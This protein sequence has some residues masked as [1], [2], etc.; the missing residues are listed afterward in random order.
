MIVI[1]DNTKNL[2]NASM[3]PKLIKCLK[4]KNVRYNIIS[5]RKQLYILL[6]KQP[7][8]IKGIILSGGPLCLSEELTIS[9]ISKNLAV[10]I[11]YNT[12]PIL[13]ICFGFQLIIASYGGM[14]ES[15]KHKNTGQSVIYIKKKS[16]LFEGFTKEFIAYQEHKDK[17]RSIPPT[18]EII[19]TSSNGIIQAFQNDTLT[20]FG[21]QFHPEALNNTHLIIYN[22]LKICYKE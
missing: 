5:N 16:P 22:F 21:C 1:V 20:R 18:L 12:I 6:K 8:V 15:M 14:I 17:V 19:A 3:T 10:L 4:D 2:N 7:L 13:G 9:S 11:K